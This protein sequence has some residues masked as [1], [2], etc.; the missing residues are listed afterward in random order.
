M[1]RRK[2]IA[3]VLFV[4]PLF[5]FMSAAEGGRPSATM[6]FVGKAVNFLILFGG[7]AF[8]LRK[9]LAAMLGKRAFDIQETMRLADESKAEAEKKHQEA[10]RDIAGLAEEIRRM[11]DTAQTVAQHEKER[12]SRLAAEEAARI[13]KYTEQEIDQQVR[14]GLQELKAYAAEKG[15]SLARER[16]RKKLTPARQAALIDKSIQRLSRFYEKSGSR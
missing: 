8:V 2:S 7:L 3:A 6:D 11:T 5:I 13:K 12:I 9:P 16:I 1:T 14:G 15:T 4:L 10:D